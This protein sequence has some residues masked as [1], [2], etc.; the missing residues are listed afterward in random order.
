MNRSVSI[1][2]KGAAL[3]ALPLAALLASQEAAAQA[4]DPGLCRR[5]CD[6]DYETGVQS[7]RQQ[8]LPPATVN[9]ILNVG[10]EQRRR[11]YRQCDRP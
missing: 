2:L 1:R 6:F 10:A 8:G 4:T 11:C 3:F 9:F 5:R 7:V